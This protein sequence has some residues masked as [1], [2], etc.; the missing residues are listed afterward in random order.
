MKLGFIGLGNMGSAM[1]LNLARSGADLVV[2]NRT[3]AKCA[4]IEAAGAQPASSV[5]AVFDAASVVILMLANNRVIDEVLRRGTP[6]FERLV[7]GHVVVHMGTTAPAY[8][9]ALERDIVAAGGR[10]VEAPVSGSRKPA[11]QGALVGMLAGEPAAVELVRPLLA[12][13]CSQTFVCG[14]VP[15]ALLMKLSVNLFLITMVSGLAEATNFAETHG[16][17]LDL[18]RDIV[19]AG[20]MA[21]SVSKVKLA[22]LVAKDYAVQASITDVFMNNRLIADAARDAQIAAPLLDVCHALYRETE[23]LGHGKD[24]MAAV[25]LSLAERTRTM[26]SGAGMEDEA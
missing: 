4:E 5:E 7:R 3:P 10:Y 24:D 20:P 18:F 16:L 8:S 26:Q 14:P 15:S 9:K 1:A 21:S 23:A 13:V 19:D 11:E 22:K 25:I 2:W 12:P 6:N 17:D